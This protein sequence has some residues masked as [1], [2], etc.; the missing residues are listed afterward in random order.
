V[1]KAEL[2]WIGMGCLCQL[3]DEAFDGECAGKEADRPEERRRHWQS[4]A[5]VDRAAVRHVVLQQRPL[6][7]VRVRPCQPDPEAAA[8]NEL[9]EMERDVA[10]R[11]AMLHRDDPALLVHRPSED[12]V[13]RR[14]EPAV[15]ELLAE[16]PRDADWRPDGR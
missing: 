6:G 7:R 16:A 5:F 10:A 12:M 3:V 11:D 13:G 2:E 9:R 14:P 4:G 1:T 15:F 8:R